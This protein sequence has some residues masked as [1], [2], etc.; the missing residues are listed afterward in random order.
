MATLL[1]PFVLLVLSL[2]VLELP[3]LCWLLAAAFGRLAWWEAPETSCFSGPASLVALS[4][5]VACER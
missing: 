2:F 5:R 4:R 3:W 1:P